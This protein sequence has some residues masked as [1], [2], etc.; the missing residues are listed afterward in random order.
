MSSRKS[1]EKYKKW[2]ENISKTMLMENHHNRH[3]SM[4]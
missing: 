2:F 4:S 1:G 3:T